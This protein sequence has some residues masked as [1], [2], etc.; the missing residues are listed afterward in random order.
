MTAVQ[1]EQVSLHCNV[2]MSKSIAIHSCKDCHLCI[3]WLLHSML[4]MIASTLLDLHKG[5]GLVVL[6]NALL[7]ILSGS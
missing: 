7:S 6:F 3:W 1:A 5:P 4:A 2:V